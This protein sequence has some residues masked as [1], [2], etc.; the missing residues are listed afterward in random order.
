M[1]RY[2]VRR[3]Q[4]LQAKPKR[5]NIPRCA[6]WAPPE[7]VLALH[8]RIELPSVDSLAL[9][10]EPIINMAASSYPLTLVSSEARS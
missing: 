5:C 8:V 6:V 9:I 2:M 3:R 4:N 10:V 7:R 1:K